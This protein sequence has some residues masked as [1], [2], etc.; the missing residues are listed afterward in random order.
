MTR[1]V[2][3][4]RIIVI[5][6]LAVLALSA[7]FV[8]ILI[9]P[10]TPI[11]RVIIK[12]DGTISPPEAPIQRDGDKYTFTGNVYA[13]ISVQK[14]NV[15]L[16]GAGHTLQGPYN[17]TYESA[18]IVGGGPD[19]VTN[20]TIIPYSIGIDLAF[21]SVVGL[22]VENLNIKNFSIGMYIWTENNTVTG[23]S[24]TDTIVGVL[25]SGDG[26]RITH[27]LVA[28][29]T[30]G[31][32]FGWNS[33]TESIPEGI[34]ISYNSF[35]S[36]EQHLSGCLCQEYNLTEDVHTWDNGKEGNYWSNYNGT[37]ADDDGIG[38]ISYEID[39]LNVDRY[40]LI[41]SIVA[42]PTAEEELT[43][44]FVVAGLSLIIVTITIVIALRKRRKTAPMSN[45]QN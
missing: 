1:Y 4:K 10:S 13:G 33:A 29:N 38:D 20:G 24:I 2:T 35:E 23:N 42:V 15:T 16:D 36:N 26:N 28:R 31:I 27:N 9:L 5:A 45:K 41:Q 25:L 34:E 7:I 22:T 30:Q 21:P 14:S 3:K 43:V 12:D 39:P 19:Q 44:E 8:N 18:F 40:P 37:D 17:G 32:F 11:L 6:L